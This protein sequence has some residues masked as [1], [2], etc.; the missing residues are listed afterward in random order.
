MSKCKTLL[1]FKCHLLEK[2]KLIKNILKSVSN[3]VTNYEYFQV[4]E[5]TIQTPMEDAKSIGL[6]T[7]REFFKDLKCIHLIGIAIRQK[8]FNVERRLKELAKLE[9][10]SQIPLPGKKRKPGRPK[11]A[12]QA[13]LI[14]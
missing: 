10:D 11:N 1:H 12:S 5:V 14:E 13:L 9:H 4:C 7:C 6:C 2:L 8:H 3:F